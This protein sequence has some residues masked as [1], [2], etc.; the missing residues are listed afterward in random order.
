MKKIISVIPAI[1]L[2][3]FPLASAVSA[4]SAQ[5]GWS[6]VTAPI[7][8]GINGYYSPSI[9]DYTYLLSPAKTWSEFGTLDIVVNTLFYITE[10]SIEGKETRKKQGKPIKNR[11]AEMTATRQ[12]LISFF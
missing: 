7:Y 1:L 4:N 8:P 10:S 12:S 5:R 9:Y 3:S 2:F 6:G 11:A